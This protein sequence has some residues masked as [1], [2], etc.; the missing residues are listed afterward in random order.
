[1]I[2]IIIKQNTTCKIVHVI[3]CEENN[4]KYSIFNDHMFIQFELRKRTY[5]F[6]NYE[7]VTVFRNSYI[8]RK[9]VIRREQ[10]NI[11]H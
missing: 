8:R 6:T 5:E 7:N 1:M 11:E 2:L 9:F 10:L 4:A 3:S